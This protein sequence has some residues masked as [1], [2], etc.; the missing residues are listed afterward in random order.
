L[1]LGNVSGHSPT[2]RAQRWIQRLAQAGLAQPVTAVDLYAGEHWSVARTYPGLARPGETVCLWACS[3]GY[4]LIP[5]SAPIAAYHAT[6]T[7]GQ[8]DSVPGDPADWWAAMAEWIGPRPDCPRTIQSLTS[9]SPGATFLLVLSHNYLRACRADVAA[10]SAHVGPGRLA[11]VSVGGPR[12]GD[13]ADL[14]V[15]ADA[16]LQAHFGGTRRALN[17]RIG[18]HLLSEG[19]RDLGTAI[20]YMDG[21]LKAQPAIRRYNRQKQTDEQILSR[22][23]ERLNRDPGATASRLL[24][25]FRDTGL[26]C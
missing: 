20:A 13:L 19:V 22:I 10:A 23:A 26:A 9:S 21:L 5:A 8:A 16:R 25:E 18:A 15:P 17:A 2:E 14:M 6:L 11:I 3:A 24:R 4:G 12:V 7:Q 1:R